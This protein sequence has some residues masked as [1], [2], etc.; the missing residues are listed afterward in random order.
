MCAYKHK[1]QDVLFHK[2]LSLIYSSFCCPASCSFLLTLPEQGTL[3]TLRM[4][5]VFTDGAAFVNDSK[6]LLFPGSLFRLSRRALTM[7]VLCAH[8]LFQICFMCPKNIPWDQPTPG[9]VLTSLPTIFWWLD[10]QECMWT[11]DPAAFVFSLCG[12]ECD[13]RGV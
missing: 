11:L 9:A 5:L 2:S 13:T 7:L 3:F 8:C 10:R 1:D 12:I 6:E 4:F